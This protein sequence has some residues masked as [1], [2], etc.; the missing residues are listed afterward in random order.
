MYIAQTIIVPYSRNS[1]RRKERKKCRAEDARNVNKKRR[2]GK[3]EK[4]IMTRRKKKC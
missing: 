4:D 1:E 2:E 3:R